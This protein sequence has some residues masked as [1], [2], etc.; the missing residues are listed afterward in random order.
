[1]RPLLDPPGNRLSPHRVFQI[2]GVTRHNVAHDALHVF[3]CKG[4]SA[5][6]RG[7]ALHS[8]IYPRRGVIGKDAAKERIGFIFNRAK[9]LYDEHDCGTR[10]SNLRLSMVLPDTDAPW[11]NPPVLKSK[12][13]ECKHF[14]PVLAQISHEL[15]VSEEDRMRSDLLSKLAALSEHFDACPMIPSEAKADEADTMMREIL[16]LHQKLHDLA[17]AQDSPRY[18]IVFKHHMASHLVRNFR[19]LNCR[20]SWCFRSENFVGL[21]AKCAHACAFGSS[22]LEL[23]RKVMRKWR[24]MMHIKLLYDMQL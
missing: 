22:P 24:F 2:P 5:H 21:M 17:A 12:G 4:V 9:T 13:A 3:W 20:A 1:M 7:S 8:M 16:S 6:A 14:V 23:A 11:A 18:H 10:L 15:S 19:F